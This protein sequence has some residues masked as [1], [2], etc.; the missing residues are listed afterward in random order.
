MTLADIFNIP[1][2]LKDKEGNEYLLRKPTLIEQGL[3]Q[4]WLET[5]AHDAI[6]RSEDSEERKLRRHHLVDVDA[7]LGK[8][9]WDAPLAQEAVW[10]P[11]GFAKFLTIIYRAQAVDEDKAEELLAARAKE[12]A[13]IVL[14]RAQ[15][16]PKARR[17]LSLLLGAMG[18][19]MDW[20]ASGESEPS[21]DNSSTP[22]SPEPSPNSADAATTNSSFFTTSNEAPTG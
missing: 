17:E 10:Q 15:A 9:E 8:Y 1:T 13:G 6:D 18:Y 16:D 4:R 2:G 20:M 21:S 7:G 14:T 5:R 3:F 11:A 22:P 19:P 12:I